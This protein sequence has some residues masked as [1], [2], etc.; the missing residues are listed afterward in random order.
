MSH[1]SI[2]IPFLSFPIPF[3]EP[4]HLWVRPEGFLSLI[5]GRGNGYRSIS[6][7]SSKGVN[8]PLS[9][10]NP[11][12]SASFPTNGATKSEPIYNSAFSFHSPFVKFYDDNKVLGM[13][14]LLGRPSRGV[15]KSG[16]KRARV[17]GPG[18]CK[19]VRARGRRVFSPMT[20]L[21][22]SRVESVFLLNIVNNFI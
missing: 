11:R 8:R 9:G 14:S 16:R 20:V 2:E 6:F 21:P 1:A 19:N 5:Y 12:S 10:L 13:A 4:V 15:P 17:G 3:L 7:L 22:L 18:M